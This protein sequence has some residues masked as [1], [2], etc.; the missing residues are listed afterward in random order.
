[1]EETER[2]LPRSKKKRLKN[3]SGTS[4]ENFKP[5]KYYELMR[6]I[7]DYAK[8]TPHDSNYTR[9][10]VDEQ[11]NRLGEEAVDDPHLEDTESIASMSARAS[12][13]RFVNYAKYTGELSSSIICALVI[14]SE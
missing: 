13:S 10:A 12:T 14:Y 6:W 5:W 4:R 7:E 3:K 1:M 11:E 8:P 9:D 2:R